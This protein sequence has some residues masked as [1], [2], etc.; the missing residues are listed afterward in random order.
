[1]FKVSNRNT[2]TWCEICSK[3]T[4][5]TPERRHWR[6]SG[7][8]IVNFEHILHLVLVLLFLTLSRLM[9]AGISSKNTAT[10]SVLIKWFSMKSLIFCFSLVLTTI[11]VGGIFDTPSPTLL[12]FSFKLRNGKSC[13]PGTFQHE[14]TFHY[15]YTWVSLTYPIIQILNTTQMDVIFNIRNSGQTLANK[16]C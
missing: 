15:R 14:V 9:P 6:R 11:W 12:I 7:V 4:I 3:L 1:M 13:Y 10:L 16:N 5:N 8:F 2:R